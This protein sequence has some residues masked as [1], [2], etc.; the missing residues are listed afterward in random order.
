MKEIAYEMASIICT[1][2]WIQTLSVYRFGAGNSRHL[3]T[4]GLHCACGRLV[5]RRPICYS[6]RGSS[7]KPCGL[8]MVTV[9]HFVYLLHY[10]LI[11]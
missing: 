10:I 9:K 1:G 8:E 5:N 3:R 11:R 6:V 2:V 7:D 4:N